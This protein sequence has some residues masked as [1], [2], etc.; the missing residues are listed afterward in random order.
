MTSSK[1]Y[2]VNHSGDLNSLHAMFAPIFRY[3][4]SYFPLLRGFPL[5]KRR[6]QRRCICVYKYFNG[7]VEH[8]MNFIRQQEQ[9]DYYTRTKLNFR[10]PSFKRIGANSVLH[11]MPS[12]ILTPLT[13]QLKNPWMEIFFTVIFLNL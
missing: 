11:F 9:H 3:K 4:R 1:R 8:D 5:E 2:L 12:R 6:I 7:L 10:L 13:R